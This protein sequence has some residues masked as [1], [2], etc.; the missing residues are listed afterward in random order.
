[1]PSKFKRGDRVRY[2]KALLIMSPS[3]APHF[4]RFRGTVEST[5]NIGTQKEVWAARVLW[6][7]GQART[8]RELSLELD[9]A[10]GK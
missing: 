3:T 1:M 5:E 9:N 4:A 8:A 2:A 10:N 7:D 6:D